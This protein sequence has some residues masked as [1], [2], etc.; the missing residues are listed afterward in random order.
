MVLPI[1]AETPN[2]LPQRWGLREHAAAPKTSPSQRRFPVPPEAAFLL[3]EDDFPG[4]PAR[5]S[6]VTDRSDH[7]KVP[8][9]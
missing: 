5:V 9:N 8:R 6:D 7:C 3:S 2:R 1:R 4:C